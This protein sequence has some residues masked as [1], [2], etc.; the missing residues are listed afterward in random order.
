MR[1]KDG[2]PVKFQRVKFNGK[3]LKNG[4]TVGYY[5]IEK[6]D[7]L[8]VVGRLRGGGKRGASGSTK[9]SKTSAADKSMEKQLVMMTIEK[10]AKNFVPTHVDENVMKLKDKLKQ[11][12]ESTVG[13]LLRN[14]LESRPVLDLTMLK[15]EM[16]TNRNVDKRMEMIMLCALPDTTQIKLKVEQ[17]Q[18]ILFTTKLTVTQL[19]NEEFGGI[20][21]RTESTFAGLLNTV[22]LVKLGSKPEHEDKKAPTVDG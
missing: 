8:H 21:G 10:G 1:K 20:T 5:N 6:G 22:I 12:T 13:S 18:Q 7:T 4:H 17:V 19:Y 15:D 9:D 2:L 14:E 3:K 16:L 11:L